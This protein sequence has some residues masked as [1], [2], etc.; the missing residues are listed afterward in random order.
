MAAV[1]HR[2]GARP[3]VWWHS[4]PRWQR[5]PVAFVV[6]F[7][8]V[9]FVSTFMVD[10][11]Y[12]CTPGVDGCGT[13]EGA[14]SQAGENLLPAY[15]WNSPASGLY[16]D[17]GTGD[18]TDR[19]LLG[20]SGIFLAV[21]SI[22]WRITLYFLEAAVGFDLLSNASRAVNNGYSAVFEAITSTGIGI[23]VVIFAIIAIAVKVGMGGGQPPGKALA[24]LAVAVGLLF[25]F[26]QSAASQSPT[27]SPGAVMIAVDNVSSLLSEGLFRSFAGV[28]GDPPTA[29]GDK[30]DC[31]NYTAALYRTYD[32][33]V[34]SGGVLD[35]AGVNARQA[36]K[37][38]MSQLW[39]EAYLTPWSIVQF[40]DPGI[41]R[42]MNCRFLEVDTVAPSIQAE[43]Q[44]RT[45]APAPDSIPGAN[46][47]DNRSVFNQ[48]NV[49]DEFLR[50]MAGWA[51][52]G[53]RNGAFFVRGPFSTVNGGPDNGGPKVSE[54]EEWYANGETE[55][56]DNPGPWHMEVGGDIN[57]ATDGSFLECDAADDNDPD[58]TCGGEED[59]PAP[60]ARD[61]YR[62]IRGHIG[63][64]GVG[65]SV[66][67]VV[68]AGV[69]AWALIGLCLGLIIAQ[70][71]VILMFIALPF[72]LLITAWPGEG[73]AEISKKMGRMGVGMLFSKV[74]FS[75]FLGVLVVFMATLREVVGGT[76]LLAAQSTGPVTSIWI[77]VIP[78]ASVF[79]LSKFAEAVGL[80]GIMKAGGAMK[81]V[82]NASN[83][84]GSGQPGGGGGIGQKAGNLAKREARDLR[85]QHSMRRSMAKRDKKRDAEKARKDQQGQIGAP[86]EDTKPDSDGKGGDGKGGDGKGGALP[87]GGRGGRSRGLAAP[88]GGGPGGGGTGTPAALPSGGKKG[89]AGKPSMGRRAVGT[90]AGGVAALKSIPL[91]TGAA[92]ALGSVG[93]LPAAGLLAPVIGVA[94]GLAVYKQ[95]KTRIAP[96]DTPEAIGDVSRTSV[97]DH[98]E[99]IRDASDTREVVEVDAGGGRTARG[100][101]T[102]SGLWVP[103]TSSNSGSRSTSGTTG[104]TGGSVGP[105]PAT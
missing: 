51:T 18:T 50:N 54:C 94:A 56:E 20:I 60:R 11:A 19:V 23:L 96:R 71:G 34:T 21:G 35:S 8:V 17:F 105:P 12:A 53:Y 57:R 46:D 86:S 27:T 9:G 101:E 74:V 16:S 82:M 78:L 97:V 40:G 5:W 91:A 29:P 30:L 83:P 62:H 67:S 87:S 72:W 43:V 48:N 39:E 32:A 68:I 36:A 3:W 59:Q 70:F 10:R 58:T 22:I 13:Y 104:A 26:A 80:K 85:R 47:G 102:P 63:G 75:T 25:M 55:P 38:E 41:G 15:R 103:E 28:A 84:N 65:V 100:T 73:A 92:A 98:V 37:A 2:A 42:V 93:L 14:F 45:G 69:F 88:G 81:L 89:G 1:A 4:A 66:L 79:L 76:G 44:Q 64:G 24:R 6:G 49:Q 90:L 33:T 31:A 7:F 95:I 99:K 52:C 77:G 61:F